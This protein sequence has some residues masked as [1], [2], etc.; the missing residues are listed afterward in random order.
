MV[1]EKLHGPLVLFRGGAR[2][3]CSQVAALAGPRVLLARVK[4]KFARTQFANHG[5]GPP[6][7]PLRFRNESRPAS[8]CPPIFDEQRAYQTAPPGPELAG[9][10]CHPP[11]S[12]FF[13][14]IYPQISQI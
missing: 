5:L 3:E 11:P 2:A 9:C 6:V 7:R 14:S 1:L 12:T 10:Q 4:S 8:A 13:I